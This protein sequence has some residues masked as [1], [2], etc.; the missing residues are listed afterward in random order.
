M[1]GPIGYAKNAE[2]FS[3]RGPGLAT[4]KKYGYTIS[5][6]EEEEGP[7]SGPYGHADESR[8]YIVRECGLHK[9]DTNLLEEEM[10]NVHG[11][12]MEVWYIKY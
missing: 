3:C 2:T 5:W 6:V 9:E 4:K 10:G 8:T 1:H 11:C 7:Q 12:G